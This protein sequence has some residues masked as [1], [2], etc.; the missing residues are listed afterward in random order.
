MGTCWRYG[1]HP[2]QN[3]TSVQLAE[4]AGRRRTTL[5]VPHSHILGGTTEGTI[6][7]IRARGRSEK[8]KIVKTPKKK[9]GG[10]GD[11]NLPP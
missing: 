11:R 6:D 2:Q 3:T 4:I 7:L 9:G 5:R 1:G 10:C 8:E